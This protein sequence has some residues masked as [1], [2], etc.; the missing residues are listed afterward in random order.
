MKTSYHSDDLSPIIQAYL[1][2][3]HLTKIELVQGKGHKKTQL[4]RNYE[5]IKDYRDKLKEYETHLRICG[6][7]NSYSKTD[8]D[9]TFMHTKEDYYMKTGIF[10][11]AYNIQL[12]VSDEYIL[13]AKVY[14]NPGDTSTFSRNLFKRYPFNENRI[15]SR[16]RS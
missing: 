11:P 9:A 16:K 10:K 6:E 13:Y 8:H 7:R 12:G 3:I 5:E 2:D 1:N 15:G 14:P 4:Q